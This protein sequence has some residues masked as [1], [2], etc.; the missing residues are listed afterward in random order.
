M[1]SGHGAATGEVEALRQ[2]ITEMTE[3]QTRFKYEMSDNLKA[4]LKSVMSM[5]RYGNIHHPIFLQ[6][7]KR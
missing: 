1:S 5:N 3:N 4:C 7:S 6:Y 2:Q